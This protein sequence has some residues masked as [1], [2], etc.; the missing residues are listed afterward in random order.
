M[1][2]I[3]YIAAFIWPKNEIT[4][5]KYLNITPAIGI[6]IE[7]MIVVTS[8][9]AIFYFGSRCYYKIQEQ[10]KVAISVSR[11]TKNLHRQLFYA[12]VMQTAI[13]IML[14]HVP[15]SG[16]FMFP[17]MDSDLGFL[18]GF[19]TITIAIYPPID[20]LPT[21]LVIE[22]YRKAVFAFFKAVL[23]CKHGNNS[24]RAEQTSSFTEGQISMATC[25]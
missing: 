4:G 18:T 15:V 11:I 8:L 7:E 20:P 19:V 21:M 9:T 13:P 24:G 10:L 23:C 22:N 2:E 6:A 17:I 12:L 1:G 25:N 14:L 5:M 3:V 16:L